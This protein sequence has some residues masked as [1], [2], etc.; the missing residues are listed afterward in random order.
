MGVSTCGECLSGGIS[1][2]SRGCLARGCLA[3]GYLPGSLSRDVWPSGMAIWLAFWSG[4]LVWSSGMAFW[5]SSDMAF[6][7]GLLVWP[8]SVASGGLL[9]CISNLLTPLPLEMAI[10]TVG[11]HP[12][13]L[14]TC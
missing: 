7:C 1:A 14:H 2:Q 12:T 6:W 9:I 10:A 13:G 8:S 5:W 11:T 4:L 3:M